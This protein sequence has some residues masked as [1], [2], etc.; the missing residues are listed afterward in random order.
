MK[1]LSLTE[2]IATYPSQVKKFFNKLDKHRD[3]SCKVGSLQIMIYFRDQKVGG[4]NRNLKE[5]YFSKVFV[6]NHNS[7]KLL[8]NSDFKFRKKFG[9]RG[10]HQYW[11]LLKLEKYDK[12]RNLMTTMTS[13]PL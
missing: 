10:V 6:T 1:K 8:Q 4:L 9:K 3:Y 5:W 2:V 11:S 12:F 7:F 13:V